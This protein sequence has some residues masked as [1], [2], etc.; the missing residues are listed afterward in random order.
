MANKRIQDLEQTTDL[1][2]DDLLPLDTTKKTFATTLKSLVDW[3][4]NTFQ[5]KDNLE[6]ALS[7]A[8][9]KY[10]SSKVLKDESSRIGAIVDTKVNKSGDTMTGKLLFTNN[11][12]AN[13]NN[14]YAW[15]DTPAEDIFY[16]TSE[17]LDK[18]GKRMGVW[19]FTKLKNG[20]NSMNVVI[21]NG[22]NKGWDAIRLFA[23]SDGGS[24]VSVPRSRVNGSAC[25]TDSHGSNYVR[26]GN[27]LQI[28]WGVGGTG[29]VTLPVPFA[30]TNYQ[31]TTSQVGGGHTYNCGT[32]NYTT[33]SFNIASYQAHWVAVGYWY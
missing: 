27:G 18:N 7:D 28:C 19:E 12:I 30:N 32:D 29:T 33:T 20:T 17:F 31:V 5:T 1:T 10:P 16:A 25:I 23:A 13:K 4:K 2:N 15:N 22:I 21:R 26:F 8:T 11:N 3:L 6:Q 14:E 24:W 9:D